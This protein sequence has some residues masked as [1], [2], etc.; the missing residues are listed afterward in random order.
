MYRYKEVLP[1]T[2]LATIGIGSWSHED[3]FSKEP[4]R[5]V[6]AIATNQAY[7]GTN[8][9]NPFHYQKFNLSQIVF[10]RNG[11]PI[12]GTPVLTTFNH[13][14]YFNTLE[15]LD[16]GHG[17]TLDNYPNHFILAFDLTLTQET[18]NDFIHPELTNCSILVQLLFDGALAAN[19]EILFLGE[20]SSTFYVNSERKV[21]KNSIITYPTDG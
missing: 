17:I 6:I 21:T 9:T 10:Y 18:S 20:R 3:I 8:R 7:L 11:Q 2:F 4:V 12:V 5:M 16:C 15:A 13:R 1:R 14:I 19:V